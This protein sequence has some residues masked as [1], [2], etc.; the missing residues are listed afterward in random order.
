MNEENLLNIN[1]SKTPMNECHFYVWLT[2]NGDASG[3]RVINI[4]NYLHALDMTLPL[5]N[6][7][8]LRNLRSIHE[9][10]YYN[11]FVASPKYS[12]IV[13]AHAEHLTTRKA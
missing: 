7:E 5:H 6:S 13:K 9:F 4:H 8:L 11:K 1:G 2:K 10:Y 3:H 12:D